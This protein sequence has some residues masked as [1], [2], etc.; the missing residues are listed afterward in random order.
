MN[1]GPLVVVE[2]IIVNLTFK[3]G[4]DWNSFSYDLMQVFLE[5]KWALVAILE[6]YDVV[7]D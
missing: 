6:F 1:L 7:Y 4:L 5:Q 3:Q 2:L